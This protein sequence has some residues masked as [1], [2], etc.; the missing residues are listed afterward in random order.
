MKQAKSLGASVMQSVNVSKQKQVDE[1]PVVERVNKLGFG[2]TSPATVSESEGKTK[3]GRPKKSQEDNQSKQKISKGEIETKKVIEMIMPVIAEQ[4]KSASPIVK[5]ASQKPQKEV[6]RQK[7][8]LFG[9]IDDS[10]TPSPSKVRPLKES[11]PAQ[12][13][14]KKRD[15]KAE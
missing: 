6:P 10:A 2:F 9:M 14:V 7:A 8:S 11:P 3:R 15:A 5:P 1:N 4:N 13:F 12:P